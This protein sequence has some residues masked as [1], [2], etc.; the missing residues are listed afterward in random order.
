MGGLKLF[1]T[2]AVT[3]SWYVYQDRYE[4][5]RGDLDPD[6]GYFV[7]NLNGIVQI[8]AGKWPMV[9]GGPVDCSGKDGMQVI[10]GPEVTSTHDQRM[11]LRNDLA[12][13]TWWYVYGPDGAV[14]R[15]TTLDKGQQAEVPNPPDA[16]CLVQISAD[17]GRVQVGAVNIPRG[18]QV[19]LTCLVGPAPPPQTDKDT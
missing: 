14:L 4:L 9:W 13:T 7:G 1:S 10:L 17:S 19:A 11:V 12:V 16:C 2:C 18:F 15:H 5:F 3:T 8:Q 6:D